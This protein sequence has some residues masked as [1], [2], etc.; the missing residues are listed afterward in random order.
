[1]AEAYYSYFKIPQVPLNKIGRR[2]QAMWLRLTAQLEVI[3]VSP[4]RYVESADIGQPY[5]RQYLRGSI[6]LLRQTYSIWR[7]PKVLLCSAQSEITESTSRPRLF[8]S[9]T[10]EY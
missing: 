5:K 1:M 9:N 3:K 4:S 6:N 8:R 10:V 7:P 2:C